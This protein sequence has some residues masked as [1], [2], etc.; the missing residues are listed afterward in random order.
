M[1]LKREKSFAMGVIGAI[2]GGLIGAASIILLSQMGVIS[3]IAGFVLD[4]DV[5]MDIMVATN[6]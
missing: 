1:E 2:A 6:N 3:A 5:K 4:N